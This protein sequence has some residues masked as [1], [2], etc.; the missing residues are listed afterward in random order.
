MNKKILKIIVPLATILAITG[1]SV[2]VSLN[3]KAQDD[4]TYY[5]TKIA[6]KEN[7]KRNGNKL[8]YME[9]DPGVSL[10]NPEYCAGRD[11]YKDDNE[12]YYYFDPDNHN[13]R[14]ILN[15]SS[16][17]TVALSDE[18]DIIDDAKKRLSEWY[19]EDKYGFSID[20]LEWTYEADDFYKA[21]TIYVYQSINDEV[22]IC[23]AL[24]NY[25]DDGI[26]ESVWIHVDSII[27]HE[28][29]NRIISKKDAI[30]I[31]EKYIENEYDKSGWKNIKSRT[32][33][34]DD[35]NYWEITLERT[36]DGGFVEGY[37]VS[38]DMLTGEALL[39]G[40]LK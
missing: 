34:E 36:A 21:K 4:E 9:P 10:L 32:V 28:D 20:E 16:V 39:E 30:I 11:I 37:A 25:S 17:Q 22:S 12:Q 19:D 31:A 24:F 8:Y 2:S 29:I 14:T 38:V 35:G 5:R 33:V 3:L 15:E 23:I 27:R 1:I 18:K 40:M 26:F 6:S 13:I 7:F